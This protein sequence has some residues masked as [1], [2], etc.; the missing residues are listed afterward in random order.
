[1]CACVMPNDE[2][3]VL[4]FNVTISWIKPTK[5][6]SKFSHLLPKH[7]YSWNSHIQP[8]ILLIKYTI[9]GNSHT[10]ILHGKLYTHV[11]SHPCWIKGII[12]LENHKCSLPSEFELC[13]VTWEFTN[14]RPFSFITPKTLNYLAFQSFNFDVP[15]EGYFRNASCT[16]NLISTFLLQNY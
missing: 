7:Q 5:C 9:N 6:S 11:W 1:V 14:L 12:T 3:N 13:T 2:W 16:L 10:C 8:C 15:D 4:N